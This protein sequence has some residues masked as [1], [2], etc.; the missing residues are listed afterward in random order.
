M[1]LH[2]PSRHTSNNFELAMVNVGNGE[3]QAD[4]P[5]TFA[6]EL[7]KFIQQQFPYVSL[8]VPVYSWFNCSSFLEDKKGIHIPFLGEKKSIFG[9][10]FLF[11]VHSVGW[12]F[13]YLV[14]NYLFSF[15]VCSCYYF[16]FRIASSNV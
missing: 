8:S 2:D 9:F 5:V 10:F 13:R 6:V 12:E 16:S 11:V 7:C 14:L 4:A 15:D 1:N 3:L